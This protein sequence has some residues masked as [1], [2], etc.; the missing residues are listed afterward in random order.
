MGSEPNDPTHALPPPSANPAPDAR[1]AGDSSPPS[2]ESAT[3]GLNLTRRGY[4]CFVCPA[5]LKT[6][7]GRGGHLAHHYDPA[8]RQYWDQHRGFSTKDRTDRHERVKPEILA[9]APGTQ[10]ESP[11]QPPAP[12]LA[13][14]PREPSETRPT[15][16]PSA[17]SDPEPVR[18][19]DPQGNPHPDPPMEASP[20]PGSEAFVV[21]RQPA[22]AL[23]RAQDPVPATPKARSETV[24]R[25]A[26]GVA[27]GVGAAGLLALIQSKKGALAPVPDSQT[28]PTPSQEWAAQMSG[29]RAAALESQDVPEWIQAVNGNFGG[30]RTSESRRR[31]RR[32]LF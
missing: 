6:P 5:V 13:D 21:L 12:T 27:V 15:P 8:H 24:D 22:P 17:P 32:M 28:S 1:A 3:V 14:P 29:R 18:G 10:A 16:E 2:P 23:G 7:Q 30:I 26:L 9:R 4:P 11:A 20:E 19:A 25:V 31:Q